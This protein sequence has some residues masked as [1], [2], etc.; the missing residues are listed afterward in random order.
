MTVRLQLQSL[1]EC[2]PRLTLIA[3]REAKSQ[4][5]LSFSAILYLSLELLLKLWEVEV[6]RVMQQ[7]LSR[8]SPILF[9]AVSY[10][11][12][13]PL[14]MNKILM[15]KC[16]FQP[17]LR[18][19]Y[20]VSYSFVWQNVIWCCQNVIYNV[21]RTPCCAFL[22]LSDK[23][24][25]C[26]NMCFCS[27]KISFLCSSGYGFYSK[28]SFQQ[29][30]TPRQQNQNDQYDCFISAFYDLPLRFGK[31]SGHTLS[32]TMVHYFCH[33]F[34]ESRYFH[35]GYLSG[36]LKQILGPSI[37]SNAF[38]ARTVNRW[39]L[40]YTELYKAEPANVSSLN[41]GW[42]AFRYHILIIAQIHFT[43]W[44]GITL[45]ELSKMSYWIIFPERKSV[46]MIAMTQLPLKK[47]SDTG[48][49]CVD[50]FSSISKC[51]S[52]TG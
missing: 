47:T 45:T 31:D 13:Q 9:S 29:A 40:N 11:F 20:I 26:S 39:Y 12:R 48:S 37:N 24:V 6:L 14:R 50:H 5:S 38:L 23:F 19:F 16:T 32:E 34:N 8:R 49:A 44:R 43:N 52:E 4:L 21:I 2:T 27:C 18:H 51:K 42:N 22:L 30:L 36:K 1:S 28:W 17:T 3:L 7:S 41:N 35:T 33:C 25:R 15:F 46:T 10:R